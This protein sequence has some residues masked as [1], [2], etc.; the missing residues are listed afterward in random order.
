MPDLPLHIGKQLPGISLIPAPVQVLR[1]N[2]KLNDQIA[3]QVLRL[4]LATLFAP[5][6][7]EGGFIVAH[8]DSR[9]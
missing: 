7:E 6:P 3:G 2:T 8:D 9:I 4:D 5:E 1:R